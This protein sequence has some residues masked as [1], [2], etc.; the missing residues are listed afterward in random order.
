MQE[1]YFLIWDQL[2]YM[3]LYPFQ[4]A[5]FFP[6]KFGHPSV[7]TLDKLFKTQSEL[8][9]LL[10]TSTNKSFPEVVLFIDCTEASSYVISKF[11][12]YAS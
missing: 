5:K 6:V 4:K 9:T 1:N 10:L 12:G 7:V 8:A 11:W 3:I 2:S